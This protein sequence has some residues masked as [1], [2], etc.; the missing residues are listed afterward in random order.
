MNFQYYLVFE[1]CGNEVSLGYSSKAGQ[2][3][4]FCLA[5]DTD[6]PETEVVKR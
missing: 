3:G 2:H 1:C 6:D 4:D 5:C